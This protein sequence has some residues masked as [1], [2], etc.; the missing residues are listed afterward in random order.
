MVRFQ[1][2]HPVAA[3][4]VEFTPLASA[5]SIGHFVIEGSCGRR[6]TSPFGKSGDPENTYTTVQ[7]D[8]EH[9]IDLEG[10]PRGFLARAV[11]AD[12]AGLDQRRSVGAGLDHPRMP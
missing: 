10:M 4:N 1:H 2:L 3:A 6:V 9:V 7:S 12:M 8:G 5:T 11:D